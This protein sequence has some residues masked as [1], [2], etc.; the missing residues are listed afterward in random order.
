TTLQSHELTRDK[1][2][3]EGKNGVNIQVVNKS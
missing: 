2:V 3:G 1:T